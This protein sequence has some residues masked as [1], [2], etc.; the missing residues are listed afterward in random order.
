MRRHSAASQSDLVD[1]Y[2][3]LHRG[4]ND[5]PG[6]P[7]YFDAGHSEHLTHNG[8]YEHGDPPQGNP[9]PLEDQWLAWVRTSRHW[10]DASCIGHVQLAKTMLAAVGLF[11]RR[12]WVFPHTNRMPDGTT[13][14][15]ADTD[16][17]CLGTYDE[18]RK[19]SWTFRW[20]GIDYPA[21]PKLMEPR[22]EWENYEACM[23]SPT[24]KFLTGGY[25]TRSN[26]AS[27][28]TNKGFDSAA[29][30]L[31]WWCNTRRGSFQRFMCWVYWNEPTNEEH[32]W[33]VDGNHYDT[34]NWEDIRRNG[35]QLPT[36]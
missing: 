3:R 33:D 26:P 15:L 11:A 32:Y 6:A 17:Y 12:T 29:E 19:Q 10:N 4:I 24:N 8:R 27:F 35:R 5:T 31:R 28:R 14:A 2:W 23:L 9:I 7:P 21:T 13:V 30:L 36:P 16:L 25:N 22:R 34:T 20:G 18:S 1:L